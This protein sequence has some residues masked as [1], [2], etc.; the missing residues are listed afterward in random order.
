MYVRTWVF[1]K[2]LKNYGLWHTNTNNILLYLWLPAD[3]KCI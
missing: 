2:K 3:Y 1:R